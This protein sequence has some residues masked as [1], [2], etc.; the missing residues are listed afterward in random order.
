MKSSNVVVPLPTQVGGLAGTARLNATGSQ[1]SLA[2]TRPGFADAT[3]EMDRNAA[4]T[5]TSNETR[6]ALID[7]PSG[8]CRLTS[9]GAEHYARRGAVGV[10]FLRGY[11]CRAQSHRRACPGTLTDMSEPEQTRW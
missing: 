11:S 5:T 9:G 2:M 1:S 8:G 3:A 4:A 10:A 7:L 6:N